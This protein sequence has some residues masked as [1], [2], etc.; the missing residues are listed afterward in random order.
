MTKEAYTDRRAEEEI[1]IVTSRKLRNLIFKSCNNRDLCIPVMEESLTDGKHIDEDLLEVSTATCDIEASLKID[2]FSP[3]IFPFGEHIVYVT[4]N[5][6]AKNRR[7]RQQVVG[8]IRGTIGKTKAIINKL[9]LCRNLQQ[10]GK[11]Q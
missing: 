5:T 9:G 4:A 11:S 8:D 7:M 10:E 3:R 1:Y 2:V 6:E